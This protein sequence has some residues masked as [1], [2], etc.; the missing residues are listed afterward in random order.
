MKDLILLPTYNERENV[1]I[2]IPEI[3]T[4][5]PEISI[6]VID[7]NSPDGTAEEVENLIPRYPNLSIL[8]RK[9]KEGLGKAY[10]DAMQRSKQDKEIR[11]VVTMDAD[12][13]HS[14]EYLKDLLREIE[15]CDLVI[16]SRYVKNGG[17]ENWEFWRRN[18][19]RF[20]NIY[21]KV[22]TGMPI[23]D[24][25]AGFMCIRRDFLEKMDFSEIGA[26]GYSFLIELKFNLIK[27]LGARVKESPIIFRSRRE[28]ESKIS[29]HI[30]K[31]GLRIPWRL[32]FRRI[33]KRK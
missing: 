2:I 12:G 27:K 19:S 17:V 7:D 29:S 25:T 8:K 26:S 23:N 33:W 10:V 5:Y 24:F 1:K 18:L 28:G 31:E 4:D 13:S 9:G 16:G 3:F 15:N 30:I 11:S 20:G 22:L 6:L 21:A 32:F 14:P